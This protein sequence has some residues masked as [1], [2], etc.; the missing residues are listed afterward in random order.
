M[1]HSCISPFLPV[2]TVLTLSSLTMD[3]M[4]NVECGQAD[5]RYRI[6]RG[7]R[8]NKRIV[9]V[10]V[11]NADTIPEDDRTYGPSAIP[12][13]RKLEE[14]SGS[15][16]TL[17]VHKD[18]EKGIWH[19]QCRRSIYLASTTFTTFP[20]YLP[21]EKSNLGC[22]TCPIS[23]KYLSSRWHDFHTNY[24]GLSKSCSLIT[25]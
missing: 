1:R 17:L 24:Y 14:W 16:T 7:S 5:I 6:Q 19:T 13:L 15:W 4:L 12:Q 20:A 8:N 3:I 10:T 18:D 25:P 23:D 2:D 22:R 11:T 21:F 9:Y